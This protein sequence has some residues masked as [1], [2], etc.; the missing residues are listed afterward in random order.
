MTLQKN[1][2]EKQA[3][4]LLG[5]LYASALR[6]TKQKEN[7]EDLVSEVYT[8]A[9]KSI[10]QFEPGTNL[11]AWLYKILT[12][13]YINHYRKHQR[14]PSM[15]ELDKPLE[16]SEGEM[17]SLYD[18][19]I[20]TRTPVSENPERALANRFLDKDIKQAID[21]LPEEFREVV[22]LAD[23]QSFS[24]QDIA[25][26]LEIPIGTVRSRLWRARNLLQKN[27][28]DHAAAIGVVGKEGRLS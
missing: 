1:D 4:P 14:Q 9:W 7:A 6:L 26:M 24:Y 17:T 28:W 3:L 10:E 22:V 5:E 18:H 20:E 2:F 23:V 27:L 13:S 11:R 19:L 25:D 16:G 21:A 12:N 15:V 8:K